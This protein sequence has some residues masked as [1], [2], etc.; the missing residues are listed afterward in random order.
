MRLFYVIVVGLLCW[1]QTSQVSANPYVVIDSFTVSESVPITDIVEDEWDSPIKNGDTAFSYNWA[2]IGATYKGFGL[3]YLARYDYELEYS[4]DTA[5]FYHLVNNKKAL[6]I[7]KE[8]NLLL[9]AKHTYSEGLRLSY[10]F[11]IHKE[12]EFTIGGSYLKG[13][14]LT[15]G[16]LSGSATAIAK[17]DY[18]FKADVNY[19]YSKDV[20]FKRK[21]KT[22]EGVGYSIDTQLNWNVWRDLSMHLQIVDLVGSIYWNNTPN[23]TAVATSDIKEYD[24]N[25]YVKYNPVLKGNMP[26]QDF[27]QKL[28]PRVNLQFNYAID[29][30]AKLLGQIYNFEP[31]SF[32]QI[33][34]EYAFK[35]QNRVQILYMFDTN[36]VSLGY[37]GKYLEFGI[38]SDSFNIEKS[39]IFALKLNVHLQF[40]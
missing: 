8:F 32:Y 18:D 24:E 6:P 13:L 34:G 35:P 39:Y 7:G 26:N 25:G 40:I 20:L 28:N 29:S 23:T 2:E 16:K 3:G 10:Q 21:V 14:K 11:Q 15:E 22:P 30:S 37:V 9:V 33:G 38:T 27:T 19:Y 12:L 4:K 5:E 36:A 1:L 17:N 31:G